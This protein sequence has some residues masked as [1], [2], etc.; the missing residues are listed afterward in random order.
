MKYLLIPHWDETLQGKEDVLIAISNLKDDRGLRIR[1][2][3][4]VVWFQ[5][6]LLDGKILVK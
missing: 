2:I 5:Q 4:S 1:I 6:S 3:P